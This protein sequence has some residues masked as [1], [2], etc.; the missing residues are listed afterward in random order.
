M[1]NYKPFNLERA[2][3]G[4]PVTTLCGR[5]VLQIHFFDAEIPYPILAL[6]EGEIYIRAYKINGN[7]EYVEDHFSLCMLPKKKKLWIG[8]NTACIDSIDGPYSTT[9]AHESLDRLKLNNYNHEI[10]KIV[11]V[12]IDDE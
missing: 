1:T 3:A 6:I 5:K 4:D 11:E 2:L 8:I 9:M 7:S 12:E 10:L